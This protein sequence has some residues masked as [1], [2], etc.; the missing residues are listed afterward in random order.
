MKRLL[1]LALALVISLVETKA[2]CSSEGYSSECIQK[3]NKSYH[4]LKSFSIECHTSG[5][6]E[7]SV[8]FTK[9]TQYLLNLCPSI[10]EQ[11]N[12]VVAIYDSQRHLVATNSSKNTCLGTLEFPCNATGIYY[13]Q[14]TF[15]N[16]DR[17]CAGSTIAFRRSSQSTKTL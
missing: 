5:Q 4:Y 15:K 11:T 1:A 17:G 12:V 2:Q 3:I 13:I 7:Q 9:G 6:L 8:V 16:A 10:D 14:Y